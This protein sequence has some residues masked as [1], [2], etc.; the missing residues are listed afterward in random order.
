MCASQL[1]GGQM[2]GIARKVGWQVRRWLSVCWKGMG[3]SFRSVQQEG[4]ELSEVTR[5]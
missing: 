5:T 2:A 4:L 3:F 1:G